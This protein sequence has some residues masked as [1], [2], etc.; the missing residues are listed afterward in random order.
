MREDRMRP[1]LYARQ[2]IPLRKTLNI[3]SI[4]YNLVLDRDKLFS[5]IHSIDMHMAHKSSKI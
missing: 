3:V 1:H 2:F 4:V 5:Y